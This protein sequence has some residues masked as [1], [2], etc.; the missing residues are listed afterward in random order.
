MLGEC[1]CGN[2]K[3]EVMDAPA[4]LYRCHCTLCQKQ[5]GAGANAAFIT[6]EKNVKWV[7]GREQVTS[8]RK[9]TG[10]GSNFCSKCGCPVPNIVRGEPFYWVPAGL[11][12]NVSEL[13][14][15]VHLHVK[16][17]A[18]WDVSPLEGRVYETMPSL[19]EL[20]EL[21]HE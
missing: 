10:F 3:V 1:I 19:E 13:S 14:V 20:V 9:K 17:R 18:K 7:K 2:V 15:A 5:S 12:E 6:H 11:L 16:D 21:L 4:R 8:Y